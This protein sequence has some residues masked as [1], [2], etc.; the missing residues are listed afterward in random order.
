LF[1]HQLYV[2]VIIGEGITH[3]LTF[4]PSGELAEEQD[5]TQP[6]NALSFVFDF[7]KGENGYLSGMYLE[8]MHALGGTS[9]W[10]QWPPGKRPF[11]RAVLGDNVVPSDRFD[12][13]VHCLRFDPY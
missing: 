6:G 2:S 7:T 3:L 10:M 12:L 8:D 4:K 11:P 5:L 9:L 1:N 13:D